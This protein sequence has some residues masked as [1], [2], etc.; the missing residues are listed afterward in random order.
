[1]K[2]YIKKWCTLA[3]ALLLAVALLAGCGTSASS[4]ASNGG[5]AATSSSSSQAQTGTATSDAVKAEDLDAS[6]D[7]STATTIALDGTSA[8]VNGSGATASGSTVT[9][10]AAGTY[11]LSG[12]LDDGQILVNAPS[13]AS[14]RLVLNGVTLHNSSSASIYCE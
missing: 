13:T 9:I 5:S 6:W 7:A 2:T 12:T 4:T 14:V 1:M 11:V 3:M 10:T 8:T